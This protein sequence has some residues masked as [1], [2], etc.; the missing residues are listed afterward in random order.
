MTAGWKHPLRADLT[1]DEVRR[2]FH[3]DPAT[4]ELTWRVSRGSVAV[5]AP[6][7]R[8]TNTNGYVQVRVNKRLYLT[9]RVIW[10]YMT[11]DWPAHE[12]DHKN[13][14][15]TDNSWANLRPADDSQQMQNQTKARSDSRS[16][17]RGVR[18]HER[19][20]KWIAALKV[21]GKVVLYRYC[22]TAE[23]AAAA[24]LEAKRLHHPFWAQN[25]AS[26]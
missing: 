5:G 10:L 11:G 13:L 22:G 14:I 19:T 23:E 26:R 3:Y 21:K 12:I 4:G 16:G 20:G 18:Y 24:Y 1:A 9:H 7:G 6:A 8:R 15:R 25:G 2:L 17:I